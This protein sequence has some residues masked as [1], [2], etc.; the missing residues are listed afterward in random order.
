MG[1]NALVKAGGL[2]LCLPRLKPLLVHLQVLDVGNG[3]VELKT[4]AQLLAG[5]GKGIHEATALTELSCHRVRD[6]P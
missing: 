2:I 3:T 6:T 1:G 5:N 4:L